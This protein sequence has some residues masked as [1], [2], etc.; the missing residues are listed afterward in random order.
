MQPSKSPKAAIVTN[1]EL[2]EPR[3]APATLTVYNLEDSGQSSLRA[4]IASAADGDTIVFADG[5]AGTISLKSEITIT[6]NLTIEAAYQ[7]QI[8]I[9][10]ADKTNLFTI[11]DNASTLSKVSLVNLKLLNGT[12]TTQ[13]GGSAIYSSENL[14]LNGC[15]ITSCSNTGYGGGAISELGTGATLKLVNSTFTNNTSSGYGGGAVYMNGYGSGD[16]IATG[17]TFQYNKA[18]AGYGGA[19]YLTSLDTANISFSSITGSKAVSGGGGIYFDTIGL[20]SIKSAGVTSNVLTGTTANGGGIYVKDSLLSLR[21]AGVSSNTATGTGGGVYIDDG[22]SAIISK[23]GVTQNN[24]GG[25]GGGLYFVG[26]VTI[27]TSSFSNNHAGTDDSLTGGGGGIYGSSDG[28]GDFSIFNSTIKKNGAGGDSSAIGGGLC[29]LNEGAKSVTKCV[30]AKN[31]SAEGG[32]IMAENG[33][34]K[35]VGCSITGN[36]AINGAGIAIEDGLL[37]TIA[38]IVETNLQHNNAFLSGGGIYS[39]TAA[40]TV[41]IGN[42]ILNNTGQSHG[43][44]DGTFLVVS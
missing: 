32:G 33:T 24:A 8:T 37:N 25:Q 28:S 30:I 38:R 10:G 42:T 21:L 27:S 39:N 5:M 7:G 44:L 9:D 6:K 19:L 11:N 31:S 29:L 41:L 22:S 3:I 2:L 34:L 23:A 14:V 35:V 43:N 40:T 20:A 18:L 12:N 15:S 36:S 17:C 26:D 4:T 13:T 16:F 1:F